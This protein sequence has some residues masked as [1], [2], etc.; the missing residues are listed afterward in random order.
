MLFTT[1]GLDDV[2]VGEA[3]GVGGDEGDPLGVRGP[4]EGGVVEL[5]GGYGAVFVAAGVFGEG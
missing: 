1:C 3:V 5:A 4:G 2:E